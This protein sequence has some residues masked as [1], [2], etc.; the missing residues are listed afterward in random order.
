[1][2][3]KSSYT[4]SR[5]KVFSLRLKTPNTNALSNCSLVGKPSHSIWIVSTASWR[6][7]VYLFSFTVRCLKAVIRL[8]FLFQS[9]GLHGVLD[10][11]LDASRDNCERISG[12]GHQTGHLR[13]LLF[14]NP[15]SSTLSAIFPPF[16]SALISEQKRKQDIKY[17]IKYSQTL[18]YV[19]IS[20]FVFEM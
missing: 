12:V 16:L 15:P 5:S 6:T 2:F 4:S 10:S 3:A 7:K 18:V 9:I 19:Y 14:V 1:M 17:H 13:T 20:I 11:Q 8:F